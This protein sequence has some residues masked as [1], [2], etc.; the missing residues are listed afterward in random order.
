MQDGGVSLTRPLALLFLHQRE[1]RFGFHALAG[2]LEG[3]PACRDLPLGFPES[4]NHLLAAAWEQ[5]AANGGKGGVVGA[6][7][8]FCTPQLPETTELVRALRAEGPPGLFLFAGGPHPSGDPEGTLGLGFDLAVT[9]EGEQTVRALARALATAGRAGLAS[10]PGVAFRGPAGETVR[11]APAAPIALDDYPP[12]GFA[13][14]KFGPLEITR[15]CPFAC[16]FCQAVPLFGARPRHRSLEGTVEWARVLAA[17]GMGDIRFISPNAFSW[18]SPDG[19]RPDLS[20]LTLLLSSLRSAVGRGARLFFGTFP[21]EVR[22]EHVTPETVR[23]VREHTDNRTLVI[24][25]QSGSQRMLD[26]CRRGH[27][28]EDAER[29][30]DLAAEA[31]LTPDVDFIFGLPGEEEGDVRATLAVMASMADRGARIHAHA[32]MPFPGTGFASAPPGKVAAPIRR[33]LDRLIARG[34]VFGRWQEQEEAGER[35]RKALAEREKGLP[36]G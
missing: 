3:D 34:Q 20:A 6:G 25:C 23:L 18:G 5:A 36:Q 11:T 1:N 10:V 21:S 29:A 24:G 14:R 28:V 2:S 16:A 8:S 30:V 12:F 26:L 31:G 15:G 27:A 19:R 32:F 7:V 22:P 33:L 17:R 9:G 13:H 35:I 4:L